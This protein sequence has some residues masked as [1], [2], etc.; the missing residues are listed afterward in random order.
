MKL[1]IKEKLGYSF[2]EFAGSSLWQTMMFFLPAF[3]TD[4]FLLPATAT[5][6]LFVVIRIFDALNDPII[7]AIADRTNSRWGKF[8]PYLLWGAFPLGITTVMMFTTPDMSD[9]GKLTYAYITYFLLLV[10]YTLVMVPFNSLV[11]VISPNPD[12][13][14]SIAS[15]KFVFAYGA[16]LVVQGL[17]IPAVERLGE[18]DEARGYQLAMT[19]L[20]A[21]CV[22]ALFVAFRST[23]ERVKPDPKADTSL[24]ADLGDIFSNRPWLILFASSIIFLI[25]I[26]TRS[27]AVMYYF[28]YYVGRKDLA[29]IFMVSGTVAVLLGVLPTKYLSKR[30]G[31]R[32]LFIVVLALITGSLI[33]NY[34]AR[35]EDLVLIFATQIVFSL[36][37]GPTMPLLWSM[38]ADTADY[39]EWK[40]GRRATGL[41]YSAATMAQKTGVAIGAALMLGIIGQ[42]GYVAN[43]DQTPES[44]Q[45]IKLTMT[46]VPAVIALAGLIL[47]FFY[48]L[49]DA[50][51]EEIAQ[52]L[53]ARREQQPTDA[54]TA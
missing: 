34:F 27:A 53:E 39:S 23:R 4:V 50:K 7:G 19:G 42:F 5:A 2:G 46:V 14:T 28:E 54:A 29:S 21:I 32:N 24:K 17:L 40:N 45:G 16:G 52:D 22:V 48:N 26:G 47:L 6:T 33:V 41:V 1:S 44:L 9:A 31:K 43:V 36:A 20:A 3:Y 12:E 10:F 15:Y 30:M 51:L 8:R 13:R 37:S 25:Y 35:P 38:L 49:T 18:G 11:G